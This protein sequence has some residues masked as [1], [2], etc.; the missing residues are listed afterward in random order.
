[1]YR[2]VLNE[3]SIGDFE[4][5]TFTKVNPLSGCFVE[6]SRNEAEGVVA[7]GNVYALTDS[8]GYKDFDRVAILE[9]DGNIEMSAKLDFLKVMYG[10][11]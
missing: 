5:V 8:N 2:L 9:L 1:M 3:K 4:K 7:G 11:I 6:C 10:N